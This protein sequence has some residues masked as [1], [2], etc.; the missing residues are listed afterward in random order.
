MDMLQV[1]REISAAPITCLMVKKHD[2]FKIDGLDDKALPNRYADIELSLKLSQQCGALIYTPAVTIVHYGDIANT[3]FPLT[4]VSV[5][6]STLQE[7]EAKVTIQQRWK[8]ALSND[9]FWS[10]NLGLRSEAPTIEPRALP[11]WR[12]LPGDSPRLLARPLDNGQGLYRLT[13]PMRA[14]RYAGLAQACE[15]VQGGEQTLSP[16]EIARIG[17]D[18]YIVQIFLNDPRLRELHLYRKYAPEAFIVYSCDDLLTHMPLKSAFRNNVP[19]NTRARFKAALR[20]CNRLV[21]S[22]DYLAEAFANLIDDIKVIPNRLERETWLTLSG[23]R[24]TSRRPR[25]GW[26]GGTGHQGDL[27]LVKP[28]IEATHNEADWIFFGMCPEEIRPLLTEYHE[29][30]AFDDYPAKLAA[31]NLDL[32]IAPLED[33]PFNHG[34]SN[35]R[36]LEYGALGLPVICSDVTPYRNS[37]ALCLP[38]DPQRWIAALRERIHDL[39]AAELEGLALRRWVLRDYVLEEHLDEWLEAHLPESAKSA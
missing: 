3:Q 24:R 1:T 11:V 5:A 31:L 23:K 2:F 13:Q 19:A 17:A 38:N 33:I 21:V 10:P 7:A 16:R 22:T 29:L 37:P 9:V 15:I 30:V 34:K 8:R 36:L 28:V 26:A 18:S 39:D 20:D 35:L 14:L 4:P 25:I 12:Y 6:H 27:E 32:A